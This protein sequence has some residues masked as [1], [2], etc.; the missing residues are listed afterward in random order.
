MSEEEALVR[1]VID[2]HNRGGDELLAAYDETF[3]PDAE[4]SPMTVGVMGAPEGATYRGREGM[5]RFYT[6]RAEAFARGTVEVVSVEPAGEDTLVVRAR[7]TATGRT[8]G[9]EVDE[10]IAL[11]YWFRGG[12]I[13]RVRAFRSREEAAE[14]ADAQA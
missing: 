13:A 9:V 11:V 12:K 3:D 6:E 8:S 2:A 10:E 7:S 4:F 5:E 1:R 14:V